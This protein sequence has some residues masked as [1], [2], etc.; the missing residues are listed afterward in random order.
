MHWPLWGECRSS[1]KEETNENS[2]H[3]DRK[4][5]STSNHLFPYVLGLATQSVLSWH[6]CLLFFSTSNQSNKAAS[7]IC[8]RKVISRW[9]DRRGGLYIYGPDRF[10]FFSVYH[11]IFFR[12]HRCLTYFFSF[13]F[14][15]PLLIFLLFSFSLSLLLSLSLSL[16]VFSLVPNAH[17]TDL[18]PASSSSFLRFLIARYEL[19]SKGHTQLNTTENSAQREWRTVRIQHTPPY[20]LFTS[21]V[22][23]GVNRFGSVFPCI[24]R[25]I[26]RR[27]FISLFSLLVIER[28]PELDKL[29]NSKI[30]F[31]VGGPGN[32]IF[33]CIP[34]P[35]A[36]IRFN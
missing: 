9:I 25:S 12:K 3:P 8:S 32:R 29:K 35:N 16:A 34:M 10:F 6:R 31:V 30:I 28:K 17:I 27:S 23:T 21:N 7:T 26:H 20:T 2:C 15:P 22:R 19:L 14:P 13:S 18:S 5:K 33:E 11:K 36:I 1:G 24:G 4:S